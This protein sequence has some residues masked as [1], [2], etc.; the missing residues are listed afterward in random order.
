MSPKLKLA[1]LP[2]FLVLAIAAAGAVTLHPFGDVDAPA[3]VS[4]KKVWV[5]PPCHEG[6]QDKI[7]YDKPG[8]CP[9]CGMTL[10]DKADLAKEE[11]RMQAAMSRASQ[12]KRAEIL[13][14]PGVQI[15][16]FSAPYEVLGQAGL[17]VSTVAEKPGTL[18]TAMGLKVTP[19][20]TLAD[21]P[22][23]QVLVVPGGNVGDTQQSA[24]VKAWLLERAEKA[25]VVLSV[26]NGAFI[27]AKS[28]LLDGKSATTFAPLIE[29]LRAAAPKTN[30]VSDKR[31]V[32]NGKV[33][34]TA[35]LS[36]GIDGSLHLVE[37]LFGRGTA[38]MTALG[39]EYNW[40]PESKFAR[41]ALAD[42]YMQFN[43][44]V[45]VLK[46]GWK[47]LS[48]E[49][50]REQWE[51]RWAVATES[52]AAELLD[53]VNRIIAENRTYNRSEI[54]WTRVE[55]EADKSATQSLWRF[56]DE[57][58]ATWNGVARVEPSAGERNRFTLSVKITRASASASLP[59][60]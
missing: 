40:D 59:A 15:I 35:G 30:V 52:S 32:D 18:T 14:F 38:Q 47:P 39:M 42:K 54:K 20:Y 17:E 55:A 1:T 34:T 49:G 7:E 21:A 5:C 24:A 25:E 16:D 10:V 50:G 48:R 22:P 51:N 58:G 36:S 60:K 13:V 46:D 53:S 3:A 56:T 27:L 37:R 28:G 9:V 6:E 11:A 19:D 8:S 29:G 2:A 12:R 57:K 43:Y 23:A 45:K 33:I 26:C 31:F 41:A 44:D 4:P